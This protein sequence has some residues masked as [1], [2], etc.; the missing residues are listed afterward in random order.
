M[1]KDWNFF[2]IVEPVQGQVFKISCWTDLSVF[3][4]CHWPVKYGTSYTVAV[5]TLSQ[6]YYKKSNIEIIIKHFIAALNEAKIPYYFK[7]DKHIADT[8][9]P[10]IP[11]GISATAISE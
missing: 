6:N 11:T 9:V 2:I 7:T 1:E 4:L 3:L 8:I 10:A 5:C